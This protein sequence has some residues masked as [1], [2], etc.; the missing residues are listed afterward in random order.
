MKPQHL[1]LEE[2]TI[3]SEIR[4]I[5][6]SVL[7]QLKLLEIRLGEES[8]DNSLA[9]VKPHKKASTRPRDEITNCCKILH[10]IRQTYDEFPGEIEMENNEDIESMISRIIHVKGRVERVSG[11]KVVSADAKKLKISCDEILKILA[12]VGNLDESKQQMNDIDVPNPMNYSSGEELNADLGEKQ[13]SK[14]KQKS[15][16][17]MRQPGKCDDEGA[18]SSKMAYFK[19]KHAEKATDERR[20]VN[21]SESS[22][23]TTQSM[24][25]I[26]SS[27]KK[28]SK[29]IR[30]SSTKE[31]KAD[32]KH[33]LKTIKKMGLSSSAIK[34]RSNVSEDSSSSS[35]ESKSNNSSSSSSS[36]ENHRNA[37]GRN[38]RSRGNQNHNSEK[39]SFG[40]VLKRDYNLKFDG[41]TSKT[42]IER[43]LYRVREIAK[44]HG[45]QKN[46][47]VGQLGSVL[48]DEAFDFYWTYR[49]R[50][51]NVSWS[52]LKR[53]F[54]YR[55]SDRRTQEDVWHS[56]DARKQ[57]SN[58][59]FLEYY[60]AVLDI[61]LSLK[62][63]IKDS[64]LIRLLKDNMRPSLQ[65]QL[66]GKNFSSLPKLINKC[67]TIEET[68]KRIKYRP[69][70]IQSRRVSEIEGASS[71]YLQYHQ[72]V[73]GVDL[74]K[75]VEAIQYSRPMNV[76][77]PIC[78]NCRKSG[79]TFQDCNVP[80]SGEFCYGCGQIN[81][82]KPNCNFCNPNSENRQQGAD[83]RGFSSTPTQIPKENS[84]LNVT[85]EEAACNTDPELFRMS[86]RHQNT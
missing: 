80:R 37:R 52:E 65:S 50:N 66:A 28:A 33:L 2:L 74:E 45:V 54:I 12:N 16:G 36:S 15:G 85:T 47:L 64:R 35:S 62:K 27:T 72:E 23:D 58:E 19:S 84:Q 83:R 18:G 43:F 86:W 20:D 26:L 25:K 75:D 69:E 5:K 3:E 8:K 34:R 41:S 4:G 51:G 32:D 10:V 44:D 53:A 11:S 82:L 17:K 38:N 70:A 67:I 40:L 77:P 59:P 31:M 49:E 42:P 55:F 68:W 7:N 30:R 6:G 56:L 60:N 39:R 57:R 22:Y 9:P 61:S 1:T 63:P 81:T 78:W 21:S 14:D 13:Q 46:Q 73:E 24:I 76:K 29:K 48:Q 71:S 79:H